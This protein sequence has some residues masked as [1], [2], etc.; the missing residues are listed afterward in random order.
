VA[1]S[2]KKK[3][4]AAAAIA[5]GSLALIGVGSGASFNDT[6]TTKTH[7]TAGTVDLTVQ[8]W[9]GWET[10]NG[11]AAHYTLPVLDNSA[12]GH[13]VETPI[14]AVRN[15]GTIAATVV[16]QNLAP[17]ILTDG[18]AEGA[19]FGNRLD[20]KAYLVDSDGNYLGDSVKVGAGQSFYVKVVVS[21]KYELENLDSGKTASVQLS[22]TGTA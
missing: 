21:N 13:A 22:F 15:T 7:V 5:V 16:N 19:D 1:I 4:L 20:A 6:V 17:V 8:Q 11:T 18:T 3:T 9:N 12:Q 10:V 14:L 2:A